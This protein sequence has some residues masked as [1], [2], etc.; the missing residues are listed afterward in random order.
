M[1]CLYFYSTSLETLKCL[2]RLPSTEKGFHSLTLVLILYFFSSPGDIP[3][4]QNVEDVVSEA[5]QPPD[6]EETEVQSPMPGEMASVVPV[7]TED[8]M[9]EST[10]QVT[11]FRPSTYSSSSSLSSADIPVTS[12]IPLPP[13]LKKT[14]EGTKQSLVLLWF[15]IDLE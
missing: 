7:F 12:T 11:Q 2:F 8:A 10:S 15:R 13:L 9:T 1:F 5:E 3:V 6:Y 14:D 4:E